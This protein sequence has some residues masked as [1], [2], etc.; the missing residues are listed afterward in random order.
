[1]CFLEAFILMNRIRDTVRKMDPMITCRPWNPVAMKNVD[2]YTESAMQKGA[3]LYSNPCSRVNRAPSVMVMAR[4]Q[5]ALAF[6]LSIIAWWA[7]VTDTP[8]DRSRIVFRRGILMGLKGVIEAG[9]QAWPSS[10]VGE[11]LL[12][13]NAQKNDTK[14]NTSEAMNSTIPVFSPFMT[15]SV[16]WP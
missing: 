6:F 1:M 7:H 2:P 15:T 16:W 5:V 4:A 13:K 14:K 9:G 12:W 10:T 11:I 3:S 8:E